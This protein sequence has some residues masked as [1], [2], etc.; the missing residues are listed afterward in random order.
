MA[1]ERDDKKSFYEKYGATLTPVILTALFS[2]VGIH[3]SNTYQASTSATQLISEREKAE[4]ELRA[5]MF[6]DLISPIIGDPKK[7]PPERER[8][9]VELLALN[10]G[11]HFELKPLMRQVDRT[12][13]HA[14]GSALNRSEREKLELERES[15]RS[16]ARRVTARQIAMLL[17]QGTTGDQTHILALAF[18]EW[19]GTD[20]QDLKNNQEQIRQGYLKTKQ[21]GTIGQG[22]AI[23]LCSPDLKYTALV[24]LDNCDWQNQTC[25]MN[26]NLMEK[27]CATTQVNSSEEI[28][29]A[30]KQPNNHPA[31]DMQFEIGWF[32]FPLTDNSLLSDGN[33]FAIVVQR[34][35]PEYRTVAIDFVWFPKAYFAPRERPINYA[36]IRKKLHIEPNR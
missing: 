29:S 4:S 2:F 7:I 31:A 6:K 35:E 26:V 27:E 3:I 10:F 12:L 20:K 22:E 28:A 21:V 34:I 1:D 5:S 24:T 33:R 9:L 25:I 13:A 16:I 8:L 36:D 15:L 17:N 19:G 18:L 32:D 11:E 23:K 14:K 30:A